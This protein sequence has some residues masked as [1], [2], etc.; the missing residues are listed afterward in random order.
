[1]TD[2]R[3]SN[4]A[5]PVPVV[6]DDLVCCGFCSGER[7]SWKGEV[8][9]GADCFWVA[10]LTFF[11][12]SQSHSHGLPVINAQSLL[13]LLGD[14]QATA[15]GSGLGLSSSRMGAK[16]LIAILGRRL[17]FNWQTQLARARHCDVARQFNLYSTKPHC[18]FCCGW[19]SPTHQMGMR[20]WQLWHVMACQAG[21]QTIWYFTV[22]GISWTATAQGQIALS[23]AKL[24]SVNFSPLFALNK[25]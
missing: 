7:D 16:C 5:K 8:R 25:P 2:Y 1:M 21:D 11:P 17:V 9:V 14:C 18:Q 13:L 22:V 20:S 23:T 4:G 12:L 3:F 6:G 10:F 24:S 19:F 15:K